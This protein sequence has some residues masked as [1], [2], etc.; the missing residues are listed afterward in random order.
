M[1]SRRR[2]F[3]VYTRYAKTRR[4]R[5]H[6]KQTETARTSRS[7]GRWRRKVVQLRHGIQEEGESTT[8]RAIYDPLASP[9][10]ASD[11]V[12]RIPEYSLGRLEKMENHLSHLEKDGLK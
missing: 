2:P 5:T 1:K 12:L 9:I 11:A 7:G 4:A 8:A 3:F 6:F 10:V